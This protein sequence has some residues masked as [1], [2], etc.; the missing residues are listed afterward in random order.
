MRSQNTPQKV[1]CSLEFKLRNVVLR[2]TV[3][4]LRCFNLSA[5]VSKLI[6]LRASPLDGKYKNNHVDLNIKLPPFH[7]WMFRPLSLRNKPRGTR[8]ELKCR[9]YK[10]HQVLT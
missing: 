4:L 6:D 8:M 10:T 9:S 5:R 7:F 3:I 2:G 1:K